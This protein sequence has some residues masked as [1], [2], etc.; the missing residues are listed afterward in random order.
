[1]DSDWYV[2]ARDRLMCLLLSTNCSLPGPIL[3][4]R[5]SEYREIDDVGEDRE[6][7]LENKQ[8]LWVIRVDDQ[9]TSL[10]FGSGQLFNS[11]IIA[12][13]LA[14]TTISNCFRD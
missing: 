12:L 9:G 10:K 4:M 3:N 14:K 8:H 13:R 1:M 2:T 5:M 11:A 6:L 7:G